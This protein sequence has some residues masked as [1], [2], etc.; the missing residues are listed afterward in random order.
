MQEQ[1]RHKSIQVL[2]TY[3]CDAPIFHDHAGKDFL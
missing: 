3:V 1:S 2:S